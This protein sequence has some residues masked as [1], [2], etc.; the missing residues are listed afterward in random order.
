MHPFHS[1][2]IVK[3]IFNILLVA[4]FQSVMVEISFTRHLQASHNPND[5][6]QV[7]TII[8]TKIQQFLMGSCFALVTALLARHH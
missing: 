8:A 1:I 3:N 5:I 4:M 2:L 6:L 7:T